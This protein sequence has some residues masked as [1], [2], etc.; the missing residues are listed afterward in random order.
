MIP[1]KSSVVSSVVTTAALAVSSPAK[2]FIAG[3]FIAPMPFFF[4]GL[5]MDPYPSKVAMLSSFIIIL[6]DFLGVSWGWGIFTAVTIGTAVDIWK[7]AKLKPK[8]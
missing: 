5:I 4:F 3:A 6:L 1:S 2:A 7:K 8:I